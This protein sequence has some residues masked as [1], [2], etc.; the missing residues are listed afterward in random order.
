MPPSSRPRRLPPLLRFYSQKSVPSH[1]QSGGG[2]GG[3]RMR[4][5]LGMILLVVLFSK[6]AEF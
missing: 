2:R 6:A 1:M 4:K 5:W 3:P